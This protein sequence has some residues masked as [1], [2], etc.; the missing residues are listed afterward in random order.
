MTACPGALTDLD[1]DIWMWHHFF[2]VKAINVTGGDLGSNAVSL[3]QRFEIDSKA[4][5][6]ITED[7]F[8]FGSIEAVETGG[9]TLRL[10]AD[11]RVLLKL[12]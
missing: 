1:D 4:M 7:Q 3:A 6:K 8:L 10:N 12:T 9:A 2:T 11:S 5:R